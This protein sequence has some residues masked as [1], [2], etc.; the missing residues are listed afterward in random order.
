VVA[1]FDEGRMARAIHNLARNAIE[2]MADRGGTLRLDARMDQS[3]LLISVSDTGSGIPKEI[4]GR[5]FQSFV[6]AGKKGGTGLGLAIVKKI[7]E[8]HG[9]NVTVRSSDSGVTFELRVP[10]GD[11]RSSAP[12]KLLEAAAVKKEKPKTSSKKR[13][14]G[15]AGISKSQE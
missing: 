3:D 4:E 11:S 2:A 10:Q 5:L 9:G 13:K 1:R 12:P 7:A 8:E 6:T 15:K 14:S